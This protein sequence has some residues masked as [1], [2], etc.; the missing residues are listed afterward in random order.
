MY[1]SSIA[2]FPHTLRG[3]LKLH[4]E[5]TLVSRFHPTKDVN[6][7]QLSH[8]VRHTL[9]FIPFL[10]SW[11]RRHYWFSQTP[12]KRSRTVQGNCMGQQYAIDMIYAFDQVGL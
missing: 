7:I 8:P 4:G 6:G 5:E 3:K 11:L 1:R 12:G 10:R 2:C 9:G